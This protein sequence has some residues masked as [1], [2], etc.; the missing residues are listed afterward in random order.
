[1]RISRQAARVAVL[2]PDGSVFLFRYDNEEVGVHWALPGGGLDH[3]ESPRE[4]ARRELR[5]ETG[6][7][8]L[9]PG[10]LLCT[11]E[12]DFTLPTGVRVRQHEHIHLAHGQHQEPADG[13]AAAHADDKILHGRWWTP[14]EL[15]DSPD[16]LWPPQL[17]ALLAAVR[18][19]N[20][21]A[22]DP[23]ALGYVPNAAPPPPEVLWSHG[24]TLAAWSA[25]QRLPVHNYQVDDAGLHS[26]DVG[27][28]WWSLTWVE[29]GRAVLYGID[30]DYS[31]TIAQDPPVDL[32]ADGPAWLPWEWL[33]ALVHGEESLGFVYWW[34][35][36]AWGR[37]PY[38]DEVPDDGIGS[39]VPDGDGEVRAVLEALEEDGVDAAELAR[40]GTPEARAAAAR[41]VRRPQL[42]AGHGEP[43]GRRVPC[44]LPEQY[45]GVLAVALRATAE[46]P[47]PA[48]AASPALE[49]LTA[50]MRAN[51]P[52]ND[53]CC[54]L[55]ASFVD[56]ADPGNLSRADGF[57]DERGKRLGDEVCGLLG[58]LRR[59]DADA[60]TA[61][62]RWMYL[63]VQITAGAD[64]ADPADSD[65]VTVDRAHDHLPGWWRA[66]YGGYQARPETLA[67]EMASRAPHWRP[68]WARL[69]DEDIP[70]NGAP[71]ELCRPATAPPPAP[72]PAA[73]AAPP[74]G[75]SR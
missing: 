34:A 39:M 67:R 56:G 21:A 49:R 20:G 51:L 59:T 38:S 32:L 45:A 65:P 68:A 72:S 7:T 42:P 28:G 2:D 14:A 70:G 33:T 15:A 37:A 48:P 44:D 58:D 50:W 27:N 13:L 64:P 40:K 55:A 54:L 47:R 25:G 61:A 57:H 73:P 17:P 3:G 22:P 9:E 41:T 23:V 10:P 26:A 43:P 6:W 52:W 75:P 69:L 53:G 35:D 71:A 36:G 66:R 1:M 29:G 62:G 5:E 46:L 18:G 11:W 16:P 12:H 31:E 8:D 63:R 74:C 30:N 24:A 19:A 60:D 4:G